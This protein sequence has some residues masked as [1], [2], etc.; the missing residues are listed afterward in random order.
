MKTTSSAYARY[1]KWTDFSALK[2]LA[3]FSPPSILMFPV[4]IK[5]IVQSALKN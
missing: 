1:K 3:V 5:T 2:P 4:K